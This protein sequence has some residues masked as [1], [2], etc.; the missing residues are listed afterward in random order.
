[1]LTMILENQFQKWPHRSLATVLSAIIDSQS[2]SS[3]G[4]GGVT[5]LSA[6]G[7]RA[8]DL[9]SCA[10]AT[11]FWLVQ[12]P[13]GCKCRAAV[14]S[15]GPSG[16]HTHRCPWGRFGFQPQLRA[17]SSSTCPGT[18][19]IHVCLCFLLQATQFPQKILK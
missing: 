6:L 11:T 15:W 1:M 19:G 7:D 17:E 5:H 12:A 9:L 16:S 2:H 10:P 4:L 3:A 14:L 13:S 18:G 8:T